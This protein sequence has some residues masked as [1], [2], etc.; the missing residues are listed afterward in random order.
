MEADT[1][2]VAAG[3]GTA[4]AL[5]HAARAPLRVRRLRECVPALLVAAF[6]GVARVRLPAIERVVTSAG[7]T[8]A[9]VSP[10]NPDAAS[11]NLLRV[12]AAA[13]RELASRDPAAAAAASAILLPDP[14]AVAAAAAT[15][16]PHATV[17]LLRLLACWAAL[18]HGVAS[19]LHP[20]VATAAAAATDTEDVSASV[21]PDA[22]R[23]SPA[24]PPRILPFGLPFPDLPPQGGSSAP[25]AEPLHATDNLGASR[26]RFQQLS[27][28]FLPSPA[29]SGSSRRS[30]PSSPLL[31]PSLGIVGAHRQRR[32]R[33]NLEVD[34][35]GQLDVGEPDAL[36]L[37]NPTDTPHTR[38]LKQRRTRLLRAAADARQRASNAAAAAR[39]R[40]ARAADSASATFAE[41]APA[42]SSN[43]SSVGAGRSM[44]PVMSRALPSA[45]PRAV[46]VTTAFQPHPRRR[47]PQSVVAAY[48][49]G[50]R[51]ALIRRPRA[52]H[53]LAGSLGARR[54]GGGGG[55][56]NRTNAHDV[57]A[58]LDVGEG[59]DDEE[60]HGMD[61]DEDDDLEYDDDG[62][63]EANHGE[64]R[65]GAWQGSSGST[66]SSQVSDTAPFRR[67]RPRPD[68]FQVPPDDEDDDY[69]GDD[70]LGSEPR[71]DPYAFE[72]PSAFSSGAPLVPGNAAE[73]SV[74]LLEDAA[75]AALGSD[76]GLPPAL[77]DT[78]WR[79]LV[80][81][82]RR[83][84]D[85][86]LHA[87]K[88]A[89]HREAV[90]A[91]DDRAV[92]AMQKEMESDVA[93]PQR[94]RD[95]AAAARAAAALRDRHRRAVVLARARADAE[96]AAAARAARRRHAQDRATTALVAAAAQA[97][98]AALR[99][100]AL[101]RRR[102][103]AAAAA[104]RAA[105]DTARA[106]RLRGAVRDAAEAALE[107]TRTEAAVRRAAT[108]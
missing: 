27:D 98:R 103:D 90:R 49:A 38:L 25:S 24:S 26:D 92:R 78:V 105:A 81:D 62:G 20:T 21:A 33:F 32:A 71:L 36:L 52:S 44:R 13:V 2:A 9:A 37:P 4:N 79:A 10:A 64:L 57:E 41:P 11:R 47:P 6:E 84:L 16:R 66:A 104:A 108:E 8:A 85:A 19:P 58:S 12:A 61:D 94:L 86:R 82:R 53:T 28:D 43:S 31:P 77:G 99:E 100:T 39:G 14:V 60:E 1:A 88:V 73:A 54:G 29:S 72:A 23:P 102:A 22:D 59:D 70:G 15:G 34:S 35:Y 40:A 45:R 83:R 55:R 80:A 46:P 48:V 76:G 74:A 95:R 42:S 89:A 106:E 75:R 65:E 69:Y 96:H 87:R 18:C 50:P 3:V 67:A 101:D 68:P 7:A 51:P 63:N 107:A 56:S 30:P 91:M 17:A 93:L 5:L 97:G